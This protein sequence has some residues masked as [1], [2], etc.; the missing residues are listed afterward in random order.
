MFLE[1]VKSKI[2]PGFFRQQITYQSEIYN[3]VP[4]YLSKKAGIYQLQIG[5]LL[6][7]R[8]QNISLMVETIEF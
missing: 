2:I 6:T 5:Q 7:S 1:N 8:E 4:I 3:P